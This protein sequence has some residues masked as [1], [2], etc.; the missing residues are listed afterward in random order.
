MPIFDIESEIIK[1]KTDFLRKPIFN[2]IYRLRIRWALIP[3]LK[4]ARDCVIS[5]GE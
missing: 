1:N 2:H 3:V 5:G 4:L